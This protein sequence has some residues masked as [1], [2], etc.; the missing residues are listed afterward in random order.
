[1][2]LK[3]AIVRREYKLND[4]QLLIESADILQRVTEDLIVT[5]DTDTRCLRDIEDRDFVFTKLSTYTVDKRFHAIMN[6]PEDI[7]L[8]FNSTHDC[9]NT[10]TVYNKTKNKLM[11]TL[12]IPIN[13][14]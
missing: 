6:G 2:S 12:Q 4:R 11:K 1:M 3:R 13:M 5:I 8:I 14:K 7:S 10:R 9:K